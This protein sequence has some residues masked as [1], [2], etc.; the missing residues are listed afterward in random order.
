[1]TITVLVTGCFNNDPKAKEYRNYIQASMDAT[2]LGNYSKYLELADTTKESAEDLYDNTIEY[3]SYY[4]MYYN[5]V[6]YDNISDD[7]IEKYNN[8]AKEALQK[9]KYEVNEARKVDGIYQV[10]LEITPLDI[11]ES[12]YDEV[13]EYIDEFIDKYPNYEA[14]TGDELIKIKEEYAERV[15]EILT[16]YVENMNYKDVINK[17]VEIQL[18]EDGLYGISENEWNDINDYVMR[19]K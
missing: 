4:I 12:T 8:L 14:M 2:Y 7:I 18:D 17:I 5:S 13:N 9:T 16:P 11:W 1:M 19:I 3:L 15:L 10:K 6:D